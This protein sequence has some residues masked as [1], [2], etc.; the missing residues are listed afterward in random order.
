MARMQI[1]CLGT[2]PQAGDGRELQSVA[3]ND[4]PCGNNTSLLTKCVCG[5]G[6]YYKSKIS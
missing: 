6:I 1:R 3:L 2:L 4:T 5:E